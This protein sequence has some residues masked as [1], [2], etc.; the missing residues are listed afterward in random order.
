MKLKNRAELRELVKDND[1]YLSDIDTSAI[2]DM[3]ALFKDVKRKNFSGI[4]YWDT[5]NV[6][7]MEGMFAGC[8]HFNIPI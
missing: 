2:T 4:E 3:R 5:S 8:K 7:T 6:I 1:I